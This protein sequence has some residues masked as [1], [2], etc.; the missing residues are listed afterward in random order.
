MLVRAAGRTLSQRMATHQSAAIPYRLADR[1]E[2]EVL[3]VTSRRQGRWVLP[4]GGIKRGTLPHKAALNEAFE[5]AGVLGLIDSVPLGTYPQRKLMQDGFW[6]DL[7]VEAFPLWVNI[8]LLSW[9][10]MGER[11]RRWMPVSHAIET[12]QDGG[13]RAILLSFDEY[14]TSGAGNR[15]YQ[16]AFW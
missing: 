11:H 6:I 16:S 15:Q 7:T 9:P 4:K 14:I 12:V 10:E 1:H 8:E 13:I 5:E 2:P 3:L